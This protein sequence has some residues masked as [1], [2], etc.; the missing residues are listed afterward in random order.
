MFVL[1]KWSNLALPSQFVSFWKFHSSR[2][3]KANF[4]TD[5]SPTDSLIFQLYWFNRQLCLLK[6]LFP[7]YHFKILVVSKKS[8]NRLKIQACFFLSSGSLKQQKPSP[9]C[10]RPLQ[11]T[12]HYAVIILFLL[13]Q[14]T[15]NFPRTFVAHIA[16]LECLLLPQ[17][18]ME[19]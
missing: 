4:G 11:L 12:N 8:R 6:I 1:L 2:T 15:E 16:R 14:C 13:I 7:S 17:R 10:T 19:I 9:V 18:R 3:A 5:D